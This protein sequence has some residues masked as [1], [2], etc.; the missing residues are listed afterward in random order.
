MRAWLGDVVHQDRKLLRTSDAGRIRFAFEKNAGITAEILGDGPVSG[1]YREL[2][3]EEVDEAN[4]TRDADA[5]GGA[6]VDMLL[7]E[8]RIWRRSMVD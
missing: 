4:V 3:K 5:G 1:R 2:L 6:I 8:M 7:G